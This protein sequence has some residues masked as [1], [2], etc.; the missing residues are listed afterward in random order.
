MVEFPTTRRLTLEKTQ[1]DVYLLALLTEIRSAAWTEN[2][3]ANF[4]TVEMS[5]FLLAL[6]QT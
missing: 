3:T 6:R 2:Q 1:Y 4:L 5:I